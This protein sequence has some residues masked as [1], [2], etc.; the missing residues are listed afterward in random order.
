MFLELTDYVSLPHPE[1]MVMEEDF[2]RNAESFKTA[3]QK[4]VYIICETLWW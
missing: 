4:Y 3:S 1:L 2:H